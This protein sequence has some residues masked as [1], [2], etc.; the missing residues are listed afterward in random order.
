[1]SMMVSLIINQ[2]YHCLL[3]RLFRRRSKKTLKLRIAGLCQGNFTGDRWIPRQRGSNAENVSIW[4]R[5]HDGWINCHIRNVFLR[6][7]SKI[8]HAFTWW[9]HKPLYSEFI[10]S[11]WYMDILVS[12]NT[13]ILNSQCMAWIRSNICIV[14]SIIKNSCVRAGV[15]ECIALSYSY[16]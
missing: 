12:W 9:I 10:V 5:H 15:Q 2:A 13:F 3:D 14:L 1:M 4:W 11:E 6:N 8:P 7:S 16:V